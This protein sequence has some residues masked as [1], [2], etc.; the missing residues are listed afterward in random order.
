MGH[1]SHTSSK[2]IKT[3]ERSPLSNNIYDDRLDW[4]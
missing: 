1:E 2:K 4:C 3:V